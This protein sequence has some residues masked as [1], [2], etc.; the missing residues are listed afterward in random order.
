MGQM[1][2]F[3]LAPESYNKRQVMTDLEAGI[4]PRTT[5]PLTAMEQ[6]KYDR[7]LC[8][9]GG[10]MRLSVR[11]EFRGRRAVLFDVS[12]GG[13]GFLLEDALETGTVLVFELQTP[14]G[15]API[16]R[17]ARVRH[18][19]P[20][21]TPPDAPWLPATPV[22]SN[23]FRK[24]F[25]LKQQIPPA[26]SWLVGCQFDRPLNETEVK[27]LLASLQNKGDDSTP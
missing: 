9:E 6:R 22:L 19:R 15:V 23:V 26:D 8:I 20:H 21:A 16:G 25:G 4:A 14:P 27:Q 18:C 3:R 2:A 10:V 1:R 17:I 24:L 13:I 12:T 5:Q 11:P 7:H